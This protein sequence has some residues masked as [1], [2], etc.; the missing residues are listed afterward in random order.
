MGQLGEVPCNLFLSYIVR[1][2]HV[3]LLSH[4]N[5]SF[6][7]FNLNRFNSKVLEGAKDLGKIGGGVYLRK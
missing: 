3:D 5:G 1:L 7:K 6:I 4:K 2:N